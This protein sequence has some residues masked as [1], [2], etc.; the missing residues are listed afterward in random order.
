[1]KKLLPIVVIVICLLA[2]LTGCST[3]ENIA[4]NPNYTEGLNSYNILEEFLT[5]N[6]N[7]ASGYYE[8]LNGININYADNSAKWIAD[9]FKEYGLTGAESEHGEGMVQ[10][11]YSNGFRNDRTENAYNVIFK[12]DNP[13]TDEYVLI[14]AHYDNANMLSDTNG[15]VINSQGAYNN[16]VGIASLLE[17]ARIISKMDLPFDVEFVAFGAE[18]I[19]M[20]GSQNYLDAM[21]Q[22]QKDNL[23]LMINFDRVAGGDFLYMYSDEVKTD[24]NSFF[25]NTAKKNDLFISDIPGY[26]RNVL[27]TYMKGSNLVYTHEA[28]MS[29][30][31]TFL[32]AGYN[33]LSFISCNFQDRAKTAVSEMKGKN[34]VGYT[35]ADNLADMVERYGSGEVG[36]AEISKRLDSAITCVI[37][38]LSSSDFLSMIKNSKQNTFNYSVFANY[39]IMMGIGY[40]LIALAI[41]IILI[42]YFTIKKKAK[43]HPVIVNTPYGRVDVSKGVIINNSNPEDKPI[44]PFGLGDEKGHDDDKSA[45]NKPKDNDDRDIFGNY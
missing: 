1:M 36:K 21:S 30:N 6:P 15:N 9:K 41:L 10:F 40:G 20:F 25:Y 35:A 27:Y 5:A 4:Q 42:L 31:Y 37:D 12:K 28:M 18:E 17:T 23:Y 38:S 19:G 43:V 11:K 13:N 45:E 8:T 14:G 34:N 24:H 26:K 7:R 32:Q 2:I 22:T 33:T 39:Y 29:D 3:T 16:G 44:D